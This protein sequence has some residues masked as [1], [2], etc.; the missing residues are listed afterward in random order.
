MIER[1]LVR[2]AVDRLLLAG[3]TLALPLAASAAQAAGQDPASPPA[4]PVATEAPKIV[5][6][7]RIVIVERP[8]DTG[9]A[10]ADLKTRIIS[11]DG[12]T[13]IIKSDKPLDDAEIEAKLA[14]VLADMPA[15]GDVS[16]PP[17]GAQR[18][19]IVKRLQADGTAQDM[20]PVGPDHDP[21]AAGCADGAKTRSF[22]SNAPAAD[23]KQQK[24]VMRFCLA[25][26]GT[27]KP[28]DGLKAARERISQDPNLS[29]AVRDNVLKQLDAEIERLSKQG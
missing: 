15:A 18:R 8:D 3:A 1:T 10:K 12:K 14:K 6:E 4:A 19:V 22:E 11:K 5:T 16:A 20:A 23:G 26:A 27:A 24:V 17:A 13:I 2:R 25:R 7:H 28:A 29:P 9:K 21:M